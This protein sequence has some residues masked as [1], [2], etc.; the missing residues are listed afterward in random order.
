ML[1]ISLQIIISMIIDYSQKKDGLNISYVTD[2]GQIAVEELHLEDGYYNY[3]ACDEHDPNKIPN[4]TSFYG[5]HIKKEASH[6]FTHHNINEFFN[7]EIQTLFPQ[8]F[9]KFDKLIEPIPFS[10]DIETDIT[11]E[12]GYSDQYKVEN[13]IRSISFTDIDLNS[14]YFIVK[15]EKHPIINDFDR[16][17]IDNILKETL[18]EHFNK[19]DY[20]YD[21]RI[22]DTEIEMLN[23]FVECYLNYF[24][25]IIGWNS[26]EF[27][28]Q[29]I[30][31]RCAKLGIDIKKASPTRSLTKKKIDVND[32]TTIEYQIP[33]HRLWVDYMY[34]FKESLIYNNLGS[35]SLNSICDLILNLQKVI[36][37]GNLRTLYQKD[38]L[39]YVAYALMDTILV[40]LV[41]KT[42]NLLTVDFFQSFYTKVPYSK[43]SQN[44]ISEALVYQE[45]RENNQ[46]LLESEKSELP[47]R[48]YSGG[49]V[50]DPIHKRVAA[51]LGEDYGGLYP[52]SMITAGLS[53]DAKLDVIRMAG[54]MKKNKAGKEYFESF[55]YPANEAEN[56]KWLKYKA[57]NCCLAPSG[58]IYAMDKE[59]LYTKIEKKLLAQRKVFKGHMED[60]YINIIPAIEKEIELR[61]QTA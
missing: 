24:H 50:K 8:K 47:G 20:K 57:Q 2:S 18:G 61:L 40:M 42:T 36:Y 55:G 13:S 30:F 5:S 14:I 48:P 32:K 43:L 9:E 46:F 45:L 58:R 10:C 34:L 54:V 16:G 11:D 51:V 52:N 44:S 31:N 7:M 27:D 53:P 17:Y 21:I 60:I 29:Y 33:A 25:L 19:Y 49:F 12:F 26:I 23:V 39:R 4:F 22:F 37:D 6:Y 35:Y 28:W 15:N 41:H 1:K 3:V 56:Q 38:Y 59:Y